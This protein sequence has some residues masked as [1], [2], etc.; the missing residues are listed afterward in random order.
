MGDHMMKFILLFLFFPTI[1][2]ASFSPSTIVSD[3]GGVNQATVNSSHELFTIINPD[4]N[5]CKESGGNLAAI[6]AQLQSGTVVT[7]TVAVSNFPATQPVSAVSLP[8]PTNAAQESG[9]HLA[10]ID[11][12]TPAL[13][14]ALSANSVPIVLTA[15]QLSTLTPPAALTNYSLETGGNLAS[16]LAKL[17]SSIAVTGTFYQTTQPVSAVSLPL[18]SNAAQETGGHLAAIDTST[19]SIN[20][21][22][23]TTANGIKVDGSAV[24][25]PVSGTVTAN[26]GT[27]LNTSALS[28]SANQTN[29]TQTTQINQ[30]GNTAIVSVAGAQKVDGS[31]VTQPVSGTVTTNQQSDSS[32]STINVTIIDSGS[33]TTAQANGQNAITGTCTVNAC[34]SFSVPNN[35]AIEVQ[36]TGT[37]TGTLESDVSMDSGVTWYTRGLKQTGSPYLASSF[38]QNFEGGLN[39]GGMTN[40]RIR[41]TAAMT[42]TATVKVVASINLA[43][44]IVSNPLTLRD[45]TTQTISN[46]IKAASTSP[47][48]TDTAIVVAQSPNGNQATAANQTNGT[49]QT[50]V[51]PSSSI[52]TYSACYNGLTIPAAPTDIYYMLGSATKTVTISRVQISGTE[53]TVA[54]RLFSF[55]TRSTADSGGTC[56][57]A[58]TGPLDQNNAVA[59]ATSFGC[60]V[61]PTTIGNLSAY[62]GT[63]EFVLPATTGVDSSWPQITTWGSPGTG[64]GVVLRGTAQTFAINT[65]TASAGG[66][67]NICVYWTEQ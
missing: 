10:S 17:N 6:L 15:L 18:P 41:A 33:T 62:V 45:S 23:T 59:T 9:G 19:S 63:T 7:G 12:K 51:I 32:P 27:N 58:T 50:S 46:T 25:Q 26:A 20:T 44:I 11:L 3:P 42:G 31:A 39:F 40:Y 64:Q 5:V 8:L 49:Q 4:S 66:S 35:A 60:S 48:A 56:V 65:T 61:S 53:T 28:T 34:A 36:V 47:V 43:S 13:G 30:G 2:W 21:K 16:I 37:W 24:T 55:I 14:Q 54:M 57:A 1:A 67:L 52:S 38:T 29:G 22:I